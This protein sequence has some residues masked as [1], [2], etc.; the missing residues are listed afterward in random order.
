MSKTNTSIEEEAWAEL[1]LD[2]TALQSLLDKP[3]DQQDPSRLRDGE[4]HMGFD[5]NMGDS[6]I[7]PSNLPCRSYQMSIVQAALYNNTLVVLPTGLGKTFI[8]AVVMYNFYRWYPRGKV[9]FL[10][11]TR[12][13]VNQQIEACQKIMPFPKKDT[14][15]LTG[16]LPRNKRS[17]MWKTK[18]VFFATPQVVQSDI[19]GSRV[20]P[21]HDETEDSYLQVADTSFKTDFPLEQI[22]LIVVDEAHKAKGKYAYTEVIQFLRQRTKYFRVLALSATPGRTMEDVAEVCR[23]L[24]ISHLE[25]RWDTSIDVLPYVH[26]R[27]ME[28]V[29]VK[30]GEKIKAIREE[31]LEIVDPYLRQLIEAEVL[32][33]SLMNINRNFLLYEQKHFRER[34]LHL[35]RH[36]QHS[37]ITSNFAICISLYHALELLERHGLRVFLNNFEGDVDGKDKFVLQM[38]RRLRDLVECLKA[39]LGANPFDVSASPMTNGKIAEIPKD[40]DFGHPKFEKAREC[41][42]KHFEVSC[43]DVMILLFFKFNFKYFDDINE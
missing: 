13:L 14:I 30:V 23:N 26:K 12:P 5:N 40:L 37:A 19:V 42:L 10:A 11:P 6:W 3:F 33:G 27:T 22:K 29:V 36:P 41:L 17:E 18:R 16:R 8:A 28:T 21:G 43:I 20:T 39:E 15:E 7:Y 34:S 38:D 32:S 31:L 1:N 24:L 25:V 4:Q 9:L 2:E 35:G